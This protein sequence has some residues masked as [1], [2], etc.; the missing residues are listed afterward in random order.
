MEYRF[1]PLCAKPLQPAS[2]GGRQRLACPKCRFVHYANP[3]AGVAGIHLVPAADAEPWLKSV[4][5]SAPFEGIPQER[6][7]PGPPLI[8]LGL[9]RIPPEG[10]CI[11]CGYVE[12]DEEV[13]QALIR[14]MEEETGLR[15]EPGEIFAVESNFH[16][17]EQP[18]VGIWF[19]VRIVGGSLRPGDDVRQ[20]GL[21][22]VTAP[23]P[24]AFPTDRLVL[25]RLAESESR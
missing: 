5:G 11:P 16:N 4:S 19:H 6:S 25:K 21:F 15:V 8:L 1:C 14:E 7:E 24:L 18:T 20:L 22:P 12:G 10:W 9:R 2:R 17:P 3:V 23:P 13:R